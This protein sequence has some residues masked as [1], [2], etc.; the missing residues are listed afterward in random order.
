MLTGGDIFLVV[1]SEKLGFYLSAFY[2]AEVNSFLSLS[3]RRDTFCRISF[4]YFVSIFCNFSSRL[5][6]NL[7]R[8]RYLLTSLGTKS[9]FSANYYRKPVPI[10]AVCAVIKMIIINDFWQ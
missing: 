10:E 5:S 9:I 2:T 6:R 8:R 4:C 3:L 7:I 1:N